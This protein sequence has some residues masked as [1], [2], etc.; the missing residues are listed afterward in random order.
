MNK[1]RYGFKFYPAFESYDGWYIEIRKWWGWKPV[2]AYG[3]K[4][5]CKR[6]VKELRERGHIV[7]KA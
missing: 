4:E 6:K 3:S 2:Y 5:R 7:E 1:Y